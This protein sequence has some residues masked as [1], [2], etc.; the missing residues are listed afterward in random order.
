MLRLTTVIVEREATS[1]PEYYLVGVSTF[2]Y[3]FYLNADFEVPIP[4]LVPII[5]A[6]PTSDGCN[7]ERDGSNWSS[8]MSFSQ[9][10]HRL[11]LFPG[12]QSATNGYNERV[13]S[14]E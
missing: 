6:D 13:N 8:R 3:R 5:K 11:G 2:R 7:D 12:D 4:D 1:L 14:I 10:K 9:V